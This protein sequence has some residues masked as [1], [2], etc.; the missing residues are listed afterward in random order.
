MAQGWPQLAMMQY[1]DDLMMLSL[2]G[3][4]VTIVGV[5]GG[6][7][8]LALRSD[9]DSTLPP[10]GLEELILAEL[11]TRHS[12]RRRRRRRYRE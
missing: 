5:A 6:L 4:G 8:I 11:E 7:A 9:E 10:E 1:G 3:M 12:R 2:I